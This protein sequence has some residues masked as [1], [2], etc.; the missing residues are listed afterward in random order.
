MNTSQ[1]VIKKPVHVLVVEDSPTQAQQL[2]HMLERNGYEVTAASNGRKAL[3]LARLN[4]PT[5][6]ITDIVMPE[7]DGYALCRQ[8]KEDPELGTLPVILVTTLSDPYDVIRGLECRAD[9]FIIKPYE[10]SYLLARIQFVLI[11]YE[12]RRHEQ[13]GMGVEIYFNNHR[14]FITSDRLQIINLLLSTYETAVQRNQELTRTK[15]ELRTANDSLESTNKE[16]EAFSYSVSHDLRAPLRAISGFG[17]IIKEEYS[18]KLDDKGHDLLQRVL[19]SCDRMGHLIDDLLDLSRISHSPVRREIVDLAAL[20]TSVFAEFKRNQP[21]RE[22]CFIA[23]SDA[24][25][26]CDPRLLRIV[27]ENLIGNS[28]KF[29]SK[30][31]SA[32]IEFGTMEENSETVY[33]VRDNGAGF[34][35]AYASKLFIAFE[36]LH[37]VKEF[38]GTGIGLAIVQRIIHRHGGRIWPEGAPNAG[39]T[40]YFTLPS[41]G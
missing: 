28:W 24:A 7:M 38:P 12:M 33:F 36:R 23:P 35:M 11:H 32:T 18:D 31:P 14:H 37:G 16:L 29:S 6:V 22:V 17:R 5:L 2:I 1:P 34:D 41:G 39:A 15:D 9:N 27:F 3:E 13:S 25:A 20:A 40:F 30:C 10:E 21:E 19:D 4:R 8:I 26:N